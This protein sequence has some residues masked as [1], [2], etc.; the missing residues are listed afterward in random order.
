MAE[1]FLDG[2]LTQPFWDQTIDPRLVP[3]F[4]GR[5]VIYPRRWSIMWDWN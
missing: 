1:Y 2:S 4:C 3:C 5:R